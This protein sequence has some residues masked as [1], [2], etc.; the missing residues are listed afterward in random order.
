MTCERVFSIV[1]AT[2]FTLLSS[3]AMACAVCGSQEE[4]ASGAYLAM[5]IFLS[6][7]PL[8]LMGGIGYWLWKRAKAINAAEEERIRMNPNPGQWKDVILHLPNPDEP[9]PQD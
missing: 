4:K 9:I 6:L 3:D 5:T 1:T 2:L 8:S 7:L